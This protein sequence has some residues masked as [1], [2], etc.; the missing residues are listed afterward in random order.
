MTENQQHGNP[1]P[2]DQQLVESSGGLQGKCPLLN[3]EFG[4]CHPSGHAILSSPRHDRS[5]PGTPQESQLSPLDEPHR[6]PIGRSPAP[7]G[8][9]L[10]AIPVIRVSTRHTPFLTLLTTS[11]VKPATSPALC[12]SKTVSQGNL[13][14]S[15]CPRLTFK[16]AGFA[17]GEE[18]GS[19]ASRLLGTGGPAEGSGRGRRGISC[20]SQSEKDFG[21]NQVGYRHT[22]RA[23]CLGVTELFAIPAGIR[24]NCGGSVCRRLCRGGNSGCFG[25]GYTAG[26]RARSRDPDGVNTLGGV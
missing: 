2:L 17:S 7:L 15:T 3:Q 23:L 6:S 25:E 19:V 26:A 5:P 24:G 12:S 16:T 14:R 21:G 10:G 1:V 18:Q 4:A 20:Y 13:D 8:A 9:A 22:V 11:N